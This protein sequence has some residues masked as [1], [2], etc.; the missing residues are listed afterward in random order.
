MQIDDKLYLCV[1]LWN[2]VKLVWNENPVSQAFAT[3]KKQR[4]MYEGPFITLEANGAQ[5]KM[6]VKY[7]RQVWPHEQFIQAWWFRRKPD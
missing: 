6:E 3:K 4:Q 2:Y 1:S 7:P 5:D